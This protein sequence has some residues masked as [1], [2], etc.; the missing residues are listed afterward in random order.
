MLPPETH[1]STSILRS[2]LR[3]ARNASTPRWKKEA[4][5]PPPD[6]R[7]E[8]GDDAFAQLPGPVATRSWIVS[9]RGQNVVEKGRVDLRVGVL[10]QPAFGATLIVGS[11]ALQVGQLAKIIPLSFADAASNAERF[12]VAVQIGT[13]EIIAIGEQ[14]EREVVPDSGIELDI[15][16]RE[17][18]LLTA[19]FGSEPGI[20]RNAVGDA[21]GIHSHPLQHHSGEGQLV[22]VLERSPKYVRFREGDIFTAEETL[23]AIDVV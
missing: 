9:D 3:S 8:L 23:R 22:D 14:L 19:Q 20:G 21:L 10:P 11:R 7:L 18:R 1:D 4:L 6:D 13:V 5:K 16:A 12:A 15:L 17:Q 2:T